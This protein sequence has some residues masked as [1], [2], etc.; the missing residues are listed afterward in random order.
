[1]DIVWWI[2]YRGEGKH[3]IENIGVFEDDGTPRPK[4]PLLLDESPDAAPLHIARGFAL[5]GDDLYI[6]NAWRKDSHIARYQRRGDMFHFAGLLVTTKDVP[7][8]V[9]P[10]DVE[11][12]DD[13]RLYVSCQDTNTVLAIL[14]RERKA[15]PV[16]AHL[17]KT[18]PDGN[19]LPGTLV[20][21]SQ[22]RLP[23]CGERAPRDVPAPQGLEVVLD[24]HGRP[25]HSVR[26]IIVHRQH[27]FVA[28]EAADLVKVFELKSGRLVAHIKGKKL[29]KPVHLI[30]RGDTLYIGAPGT[31]SILAYDIPKRVPH[32]KLK[33]RTVIDGKLKAPS[34][35]AIGPDGDLYVAERFT[36]R[37]R[38]FSS[39][40]KKKGTFIDGLPDIP[41]FLVHVPDT[42]LEHPGALALEPATSA[43]SLRTVAPSG[44]A[45]RTLS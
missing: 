24:V 27:L 37:I 23:E 2:S 5:V 33:P 34:G 44:N 11:L 32:G 30:L 39:K 31:G 9:H 12:G 18:F 8:M 16:A 3:G 13:G 35:F 29:A 26:G 20:A 41:E 43:R 21:S 7:A 36:Q 17:R 15:A 6:A 38:R 42:V 14:P 1:M 40:G 4:H 10:F 22:G 25:R 28:D 45:S 19:F